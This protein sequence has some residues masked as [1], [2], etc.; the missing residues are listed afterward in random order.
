MSRKDSKQNENAMEVFV[1]RYIVSG[2][3][4]SLG[5]RASKYNNAFR[6]VAI[7]VAVF[8]VPCRT[9]YGTAEFR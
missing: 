2:E 8:L 5:R 3:L 1:N 9:F 7:F 4:F 6:L